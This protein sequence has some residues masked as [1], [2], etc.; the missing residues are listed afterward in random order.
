MTKGKPPLHLRGAVLRW[1]NRY[2]SLGSIYNTYPNPALRIQD[3]ASLDIIPPYKVV[4]NDPNAMCLAETPVPHHRE[5]AAAEDG[6]P[7]ST[8][9][10]AATVPHS[11]PGGALGSF[12]IIADNPHGMCF[13]ES[14]PVNGNDHAPIRPKS[15]HYKP[16]YMLEDESLERAGRVSGAALLGKA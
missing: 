12:R 13:A 2:T 14:K 16:A 10:R 7:E 6:N 9:S 3:E 5:F 1:D 4:A 8:C 11:I 15:V